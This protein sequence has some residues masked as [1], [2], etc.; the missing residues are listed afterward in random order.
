MWHRYGTSIMAVFLLGLGGM[1]EAKAQ[2]LSP[3]VFEGQPI[4]SIDFDPRE[5]PLEGREL[6]E[7]LPIKP[8]QIYTAANIRAAIERL[9]AT[10]RYEDIQVDAASSGNGAKGVSIT[11]ITKNSWFIG[12]VSAS[13]DIAEPPNAG[14]IVNASRL[15]LGDPFD[16]AQIPAAAENIRK[17]LVQ[18]GY[19]EPR[20]DP[21]LQYDNTY[22]QVNITFAIQTGKRA[23]YEAPKIVGD[24]SVLNEDAITKATHWH[25]FLHSRLPRHYAESDSP[26][27]STASA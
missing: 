17:L 13:E 7:I 3:T 16:A 21:Q 1:K 22:Q 2:D 8:D 15:Q 19:F 5:Q 9:Y 4:A 23:R 12:N 20:V 24:T 18:N 10:G 11:F 25:H 26:W 6:L 27:E 14:Q